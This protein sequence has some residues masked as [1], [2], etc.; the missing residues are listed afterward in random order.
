MRAPLLQIIIAD[1]KKSVEIRNF[2]GEKLVRNVP[3]HEGVTVEES[4]NVKD[5]IV[6]RRCPGCLVGPSE[7][8]LL[9]SC[10]V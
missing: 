10:F 9:G 4:K 5:Q 1:D 2:L 3:M 6:L 7:S 8:C